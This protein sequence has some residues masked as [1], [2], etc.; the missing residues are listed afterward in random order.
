[1]FF[2]LNWCGAAL[3]VWAYQLTNANQNINPNAKVIFVN[4]HGWEFEK[5]AVVCLQITQHYS[6]PRVTPVEILPVFPD[7][8]V[9][10]NFL[11]FLELE[12]WVKFNATSGQM[13]L[14]E[15]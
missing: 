10:Y 13:K 7:F 2:F 9:S 1:M 4:V 14:L 5:L 8:K 15:L 11:P 12:S 3:A 6:K